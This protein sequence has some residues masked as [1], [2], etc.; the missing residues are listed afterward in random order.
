ML[1]SF[2]RFW[3]SAFMPGIFGIDDIIIGAVAGGAL[4][5]IGQ[6]RTNS[7][8]AAMSKEQMEW[9]SL[10]AEKARMFNSAEAFVSRSATADLVQGQMNFQERMSNSAIQRQVND[11]KNAGLNPLLAVARGSP[12]ASTPSGS[13]PAMAQASGPAASGG[14]LIAKQN[15]VLAGLQSAAALAQVENIGADTQLKK[16]TAARELASAT[17]VEQQ[18]VRIQVELPK[19]QAEAAHIRT[20]IETEKYKQDLLR[21][22]ST[23]KETEN[24]LANRRITQ[25]EAETLYTQAKTII[26]RLKQPEAEAYAKKFSSEWGGDVSPYLRDFIDLARLILLGRKH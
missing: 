17:N 16:A 19:L 23:L 9:S 11:L 2:I 24:A 12:G 7:A 4:G 3:R 13:A 21:V 14:Q 10:E 5:L 15:A 18:T 6:E 8:N 22:E 25:T 1:R 26:E 20:L